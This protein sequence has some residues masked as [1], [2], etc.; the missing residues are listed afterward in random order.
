MPKGATGTCAFCALPDSVRDVA[1]TAWRAGKSYQAL[2]TLLGELGHPLE[3]AQLQY[4]PCR[5]GHHDRGD[6]ADF[7][8]KKN[9]RLGKI[10]ELLE[11]SGID[12]DDIGKVQSVRLSEWQG[13][14][15]DTDTGDPVVTPLSGASIVLTPSWEEG[16]KWVCVD[17]ASRVPITLPKP[18]RRKTKTK[19]AVILPDVQIGYRRDI[20]TAALDPFHDE[21]AI[22]AALKVVQAVDPDLIIHLGD[23][24]DFASFGKYEQEPG[25]ALTVQP[26]IDRAH[27]YL[28]ECATAAPHAKQVLLEGNHD[29]RLQRAIVNNAIAAFGIR[30]GNT[31]D[32]WPVLSVPYLLRLDELGVEYVGG[33]PAGI[34]WINDRLA[35]IHGHKVKSSGSTAAL[36]VDDERVSTIFGHVHRIELAYK[37]RRVR[38]GARTSLAASP[39]CLCRL[40]GQTPSVKGSYD[41]LGRPVQ[42][43]E[44]WQQGC[45]VVTYEDG[46]SPF[47]LE[48]V[49]IFDGQVTFRGEVL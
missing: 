44:N 33:Y 9:E 18:T 35:C 21:S 23:L 29:R 45:A 30:R 4:C 17:R 36:V 15:K 37:T 47:A 46:D 7:A 27:R 20:D 16:P 28:A 8:K 22:A 10:A 11:R 39:G 1:L 5:S 12:P 41:P 26:A 32:E 14:T 6:V 48:L 43:V 38:A 49:P 3:V 24:L 31:P 25:F 19:T 13:L 34:Y 40:T 42:T 2:R